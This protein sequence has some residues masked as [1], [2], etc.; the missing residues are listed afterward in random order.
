MKRSLEVTT[1]LAALLCAS[2]AFAQ[3]SKDAKVDHYPIFIAADKVI[4]CKVE[5]AA[6][7]KDEVQD[8]IVDTETGRIHAVLCSSGMIAP[9]Q[10][11]TWNPESKCF[12]VR[13]D[14]WRGHDSM[15]AGDKQ[16]RAEEASAQRRTSKA[17]LPTGDKCFLMSKLIDS[18]LQGYE[19]TENGR[20]A[21]ELGS[22]GG[23]FID[24]RSGHI[25]YLTTSVGGVLGIGADSKVIPYSATTLRRSE[26]GDY[27]LAT[28]LTEARLE[29][30]PTL[31]EELDHLD[32]PPYRDSLYSYYGV[33]RADF[34]PRTNEKDS[35]QIM[36]VAKVIGS[37]VKHATAPNDDTDEI[38]SL[39]IDPTSGAVV[40]ALCSSGKVMPI[41]A[42]NWNAKDK[43][44][45]VDGSAAG[46]NWSAD[47]K[48]VLVT[49]LSDLPLMC[50]GKACGSCSDLYFD[51]SAKKITYVTVD[52]DGVRVLPWSVIR[53]TSNGDE[54]V[55]AV[56]LTREAIKSAPELDGTVG[57]SIYSPAFRA[58]VADLETAKQDD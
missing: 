37:P 54:Q 51:T 41:Q 45:V 36:T 33:Q 32:N 43:C 14:A 24:V 28:A 55:I 40:S 57:A 12:Q 7:V 8:A 10:S 3:S 13:S 5:S 47:G 42:L 35:V 23:A 2:T 9:F 31:G 53:I 48:Q 26:D 1:A 29:K 46:K 16:S 27:R 17:M 11:F 4:G 22:V 56:N 19:S 25:A 15:K 30:A 6:G 39:I 49:R 52:H 18:P 44:F 50:E 21:V 58:R 20:N 38:E 34:D